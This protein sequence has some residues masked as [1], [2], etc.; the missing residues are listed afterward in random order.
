MQYSVGICLDDIVI[1]GEVGMVD[2]YALRLQQYVKA[3]G[4]VFHYKKSEPGNWHY[5]GFDW[6]YLS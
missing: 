2:A 5:L 4:L 3:L 6:I 1:G